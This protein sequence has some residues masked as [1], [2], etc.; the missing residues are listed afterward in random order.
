VGLRRVLNW[1][2]AGLSFMAALALWGIVATG[3]LLFGGPSASEGTATVERPSVAALPFVN[4][5]GQVEDEYFTDGMHDEI[6]TQLSKI[7]ALSVRGRTSAMQYR[8]SRQAVD[9][10]DPA[11]GESGDRESAGAR[12]GSCRRLCGFRVFQSRV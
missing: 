9:P 11:P 3:W 6:L 8:D 1:R 7:G 5:S 12:S 2:N 4:R 10:R